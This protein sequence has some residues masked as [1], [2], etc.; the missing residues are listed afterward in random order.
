MSFLCRIGLHAWD[1]C[2][3]QR[4]QCSA[5]RQTHHRWNHLFCTR[6]YQRKVH[7]HVWDGCKCVKCLVTRHSWSPQVAEFE[8]PDSGRQKQWCMRC[9]QAML[10]ERDALTDDDFTDEAT[11]TFTVPR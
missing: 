1:G 2:R 7:I 5:M 9:G 10:M 3:C 8:Q 6:C 11:E 4:Q